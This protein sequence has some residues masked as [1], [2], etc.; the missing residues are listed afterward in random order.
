MA[1]LSQV[2]AVQGL[3]DV[4]IPSKE[5]EG[6]ALG[7]PRE[8]LPP[9]GLLCPHEHNGE[10]GPVADTQ[11]RESLEV[12]VCGQ[13]LRSK[14]QANV[15]EVHG[16]GL[17]S[18]SPKMQQHRRSPETTDLPHLTRERRQLHCNRPEQALAPPLFCNHLPF[19]FH[20]IL[21]EGVLCVVPAQLPAQLRQKGPGQGQQEQ[22]EKQHDL[23]AD[24]A[25][26]RAQGVKKRQFVQGLDTGG[27]VATRFT[28]LSSK[29]VA[30][31]ATA[32]SWHVTGAID[33]AAARATRP[34]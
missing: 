24:T 18:H 33:K 5:G 11:L 13:H 31:R 20:R 32:L 21:Q 1:E 16:E 17:A 25:I 10:A 6:V 34:P 22:A 28:G 27:E 12:Q 26:L 14:D 30:H 23:E 9:R 2:L 4:S 29:I 15:H 8:A 7:V 19:V 3:V